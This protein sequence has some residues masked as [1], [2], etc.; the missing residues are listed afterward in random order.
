MLIIGIVLLI[1]G[2]FIAPI[3]QSSSASVPV[4]WLGF[5]F[6]LRS[7]QLA[8]RESNWI[9]GAIRGLLGHVLVFVTLVI[10]WKGGHGFFGFLA[11]VYRPITYIAATFSPTQ[12]IY[13]DI[14]TLIFAVTYNFLNVCTY[15]SIGAIIGKFIIKQKK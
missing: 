8:N 4:F 9:K 2:F 7:K 6:I 11:N 3:M 10:F 1:I 12:Y 13:T 5:L 15:I 14:T